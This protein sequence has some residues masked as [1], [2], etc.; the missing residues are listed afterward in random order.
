M[1][2]TATIRNAA[3]LSVFAARR[4]S[5]IDNIPKARLISV[6]ATSACGKYKKLGNNN[7]HKRAIH[8]ALIHWDRVELAQ[9]DIL[10][11]VLRKTPVA[12]I[13]QNMPERIFHR[14]SPSTSFGESCFVCVFLS[15]TFADTMVSITATIAITIL[16]HIIGIIFTGSCSSDIYSC[17][18]YICHKE[19]HNALNWSLSN[20][21]HHQDN[22]EG[23]S[24]TKTIPK[25]V[26]AMTAGN[27]GNIFFRIRKKINPNRKTAKVGICI[28]HR[29][30][31]IVDNKGRLPETTG[32]HCSPNAVLSCV[33]MI[34][35]HTPIINQCRVVVGIST[36]YLTRRK[37][38]TSKIITQTNIVSNGRY[39]AP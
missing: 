21:T 28:C 8:T 33:P 18:G 6:A 9:E 2:A 13:P 23:K 27:A 39:I 24:F 31:I 17:R 32:S 19:N 4:T 15:A 25:N 20:N 34:I 1:R 11:D 10:S 29:C 16:A 26:S 35:S 5:P 30:C 22:R 3:S 36:I 7:R 12:G 14:H 38:L 37:Y